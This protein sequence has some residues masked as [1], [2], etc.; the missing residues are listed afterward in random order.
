MNMIFN[1]ADLQGFH[2]ILFGDS[3]KI[4]PSALLD[5]RFDPTLAILSAK[6][7][8]VVPRCIRVHYA[9]NRRYATN[10]GWRVHG[11][12]VETHG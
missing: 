6:D 9:F 3:A 11:L 1:S 7:N 10:R 12:W 5:I 8:V 4:G 2:L